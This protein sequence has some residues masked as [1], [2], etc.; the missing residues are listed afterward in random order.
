MGP[1][2]RIVLPLLGCLALAAAPQ[3]EAFAGLKF[4]NLGPFRGGR[5]GAVA[6]VPGK[7]QLY[8]MGAAGGGLWGTEDGGASWR[9]LSD[10]FFRTGSVGAIGICD[11]DPNVIYAGMGEDTIRGNVSRGDG[12]YRSTDAGRTWVHLGLEDTQQITRVRVNPTNPD[13]AYVAA[14][15]HVWGPNSTR[16]IFRTQDGGKTWKKVLYVN[17]NTGASDL[18]MDPTNPRILYAG[19]WQVGRKPW[20]LESGGTGSG[21][22][23]STD[24]APTTPARP[25]NW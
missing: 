1:L 7:P 12:V 8:Y 3:P 4:R 19:F 21:V 24:A 9:N 22:Y 5:V 13:V 10:G 15:G 23:K 6:G 20:T 2:R 16:G 18:C 11:G 25:T 17:E 14:L